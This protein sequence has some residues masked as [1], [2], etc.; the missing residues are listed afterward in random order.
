[1]KIIY[2]II[3]LFIG[4]ILY[5]ILSKLCKCDLKE[6][7]GDFGRVHL[8]K[9][10]PKG[11]K[12]SAGRKKCIRI[13][14]ACDPSVY[15]KMTLK[16]EQ[17]KSEPQPTLHAYFDCDEHDAKTIHDYDSINRLYTKD[18]LLDQDDYG[19][20]SMNSDFFSISVTDSN[21]SGV[22]DSTDGVQGAE[23][24]GNE[25]W[26]G[27]STDASQ[28]TSSTDTIN[29]Q[30][31]IQHYF[32]EI[33]E[34]LYYV[35]RDEC[36]NDYTNYSSAKP[37]KGNPPD[38]PGLYE[39]GLFVENNSNPDCRGY[40]KLDMVDQRYDYLKEGDRSIAV[41]SW[42][43]YTK[44]NGTSE[45]PGYNQSIINVP[46]ESRETF[47][48]NRTTNVQMVDRYISSDIL[49]TDSPIYKYYNENLSKLKCVEPPIDGYEPD[50]GECSDIPEDVPY[51]TDD[52]N[53]NRSEFCINLN[54]ENG[55]RVLNDNSTPFININLING[56]ISI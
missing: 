14:D 16:S 39:N 54:Y 2:L 53:V 46:Q 31:L 11:Y 21:G 4:L 51:I 27:I 3:L 17:Y 47:T 22:E 48:E 19:G 15:N 40:W 33:P 9:C 29:I 44:E 35:R 10:C 32:D 49:N 42:R 1:M 38:A 43:V 30:M 34:E 5:Q 6:G 26:A 8:D 56:I 45:N 36:I 12:F 41:P 7:Y 50:E 18:D 24:G 20:W 55:R 13:C 25:T 52:L 37:N 23:E 28:S